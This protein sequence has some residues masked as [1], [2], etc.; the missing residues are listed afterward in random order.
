[1]SEVE[2]DVLDLKD[3][4]LT[5]NSFG[6]SDVGE[7]QSAIAENYGHFGELRDAVGE[8][9]A[10]EA[11]PPAS[12]TKMG[13]CLFLLGRFKDALQTLQN[14]DGSALALFYQALLPG[15]DQNVWSPQ[16]LN[17]AR[18]VRT[19]DLKDPLFHKLVSRG[20][21]IVIAGDE[22]RNYRGFGHTNSA[23]AFGHNGAGGQLAWVDPASGISLGYCTSG[24]DR[25]GI[26]QGRRGVAI[27]SLAASCLA[28]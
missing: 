4:V 8:M 25:N 15:G 23:L 26:R 12:T 22:T 5:N 18:Q 14:A 2:L 7:I 9:E 1:M 3:L 6:P 27:G 24:H 13:V 16:M 21:G 11:L 28:G 19:G 10:E 20:L 17:Q